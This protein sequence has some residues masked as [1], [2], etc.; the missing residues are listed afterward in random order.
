MNK[1]V[2]ANLS[3][4]I[5]N[6]EDNAYDK[7][8]QYL[9]TI[10]GYFRQSEGDEEIMQD[11]EARIAELFQE[12]ISDS[13]QVINMKDVD[14]VI[15]IMGQ[16][17]DYFDPNAEEEEASSER[18]TRTARPRGP[19]RIFR[20]PDDKWV[21]GVIG[22]ISK[23]FGFDPLIMRIIW[24]LLLFA[25]F[26]F[27]IYVIL[28]ILIPEAKTTAEKLQME[29]EPVTVENIK[30]RAE[31][32][33]ENIEKGFRNFKRDLNEPSN[34]VKNTLEDI[35][36]FIGQTFILIFKA[37]GKIFGF[38]IVLFGITLFF[39]LCMALFGS[40]PF[41]DLHGHG[42]YD[43]IS[44]HTLSEV[45]FLS[46][47][48]ATF[49]V[50]GILTLI[51]VPIIALVY[52]GIAILFNVRAGLKGLGIALTSLW[53]V[54]IA[55]CVVIGI[56][57]GTQFA[58]ETRLTTTHSIMQPKGDVLYIDILHDKHF[59][60]HFKN[61][62]DR[63]FELF[64]LEDDD[65][66]LGWPYLDIVESRTDSFEIEIIRY[67][68]GRTQKTAIRNAEDIEIKI[69]QTDSL[70]QFSPYY[71]F[72]KD[73]K[74]RGQHVKYRIKVPIGKAIHLNELSDRI[75]YDIENVQNERDARMVEKTW[76][77][78]PDG[79]S[80]EAEPGDA[81]EDYEDNEEEE[82]PGSDEEEVEEE[83]EV[84]IEKALEEEQEPQQ[85]LHRASFPLDIWRMLNALI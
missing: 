37:F 69:D 60:D 51:C 19:K 23:Y 68:H 31:K 76:T 83:R 9:E 44:W 46:S 59:S 10:R 42:N 61:H 80:D 15:A 35:F 66:I 34:K 75:N 71:W 50:A 47:D 56:Q 18:T 62:D 63:P 29:G 79:L 84:A 78:T 70:L 16:P 67:A 58:N 5:F 48:Q 82:A 7:L 43:A 33:K 8:G 81:F 85:R 54:G 72:P 22:G 39:G 73:N 65:L 2:A 77:M 30:K 74:Y 21:G 53:F 38:I 6:I 11:I 32:E 41:W 3:G 40:F 36:S 28:W 49:S 52:A 24:L 17:E 27:L 14:E 55:I 12:R 4:I 26:G 45:I 13:K 64:K 57:L 20:D 25:G 1:T